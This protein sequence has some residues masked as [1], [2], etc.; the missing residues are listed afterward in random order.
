MLIFG[1][2][3]K[4]MRLV[5]DAKEREA[6]PVDVIEQIAY[7]H[8]WSF[9]RTA[10]DEI[11]VCITGSKAEYYV[12]FSWMEDFEALHLACSFTLNVDASRRSEMIDLLSIIN[13]K[14]LVGHFDYW[15]EDRAVMFRQTL[16]L[17][18]GLHPND[19]QVKMLLMTALDACEEHFVACESV[20]RDGMNAQ[21]AL[22]HAMFETI[23]NA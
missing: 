13:E 22:R 10:E 12:S 1:M 9:E 21:V 17:S 11:A 20:A 16:L 3:G 18:G 19:A 5:H 6:H 14:M 7:G 4:E 23:G 2:I 15:T 8:D